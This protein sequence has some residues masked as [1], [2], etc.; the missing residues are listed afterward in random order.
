L[1]VKALAAAP[2]STPSAVESK[3]HAREGARA[4]RRTGTAFA[5]LEVEE[6]NRGRVFLLKEE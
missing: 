4:S 5:T 1:R 2:E 6:T 3:P